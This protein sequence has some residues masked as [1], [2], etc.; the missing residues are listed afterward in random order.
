MSCCSS[1][2]GRATRWSTPSSCRWWAGNASWRAPRSWRALAAP[3][4]QGPGGRATPPPPASPPPVELESAP[5][6]LVQVTLRPEAPLKGGR[7]L[8][9]VKKAQGL[10]AVHAITPPPAAFE[11]DDFEGRFS[12][13]LDSPLPADRIVAALTAV[14]DVEGG[15]GG[16]G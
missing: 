8:L 14:G 4:P 2:S 13:R 5:G 9:V 11:A 7:A 1:C 15:G 16:G 3:R 6:R 10:G 12:L